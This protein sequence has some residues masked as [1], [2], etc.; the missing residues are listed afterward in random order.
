MLALDGDAQARVLTALDALTLAPEQFNMETNVYLGLRSIF[1]QLVR[2]KSDD[3]LRDVVA[4]MWD[5]AVQLEDGNVSDAEAGAARR[6]RKRCA[7]RSSAAPATRRS[8]SSPTSCAPRST[9]S[10][11]RSPSRCARIRSRS[12]GRSIRIRACCARRISRA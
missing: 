6:R 3:Q 11:R 10:C 5:M 4:R 8:R 12:R 2:A 1:W 9:S 7:R